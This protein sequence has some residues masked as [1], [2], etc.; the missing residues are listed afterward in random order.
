MCVVCD[1]IM[2]MIFT[3]RE[4]EEIERKREVILI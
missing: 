3:E 4:E 1:F 2:C